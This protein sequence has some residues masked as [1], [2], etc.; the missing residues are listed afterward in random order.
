MVKRE[1]WV[2]LRAKKFAYVADDY[3]AA[4][5]RAEMISYYDGYPEKT[6][7]VRGKLTYPEEEK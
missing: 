7:V 3:A 4:Q 5:A 2:V 1:V 6:K